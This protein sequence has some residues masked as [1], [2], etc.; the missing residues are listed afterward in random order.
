MC[1]LFIRLCACARDLVGHEAFGPALLANP[2]GEFAKLLANHAPMLPL[3]ATL[4]A[5]LA[6][7]ALEGCR[8]DVA[9]NCELGIL[10]N[11]MEQRLGLGRGLGFGLRIE[12][13]DRQ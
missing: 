13:H 5:H 7:E 12:R 10:L 8:G 9:A 2:V 1:S 4:L 3:P 6:I 11:F